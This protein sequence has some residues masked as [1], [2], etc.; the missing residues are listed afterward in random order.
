MPTEIDNL[1]QNVEQVSKELTEEKRG[2]QLEKII[3]MDSPR[4]K[5]ENDEFDSEKYA[6]EIEKR[7]RGNMYLDSVAELW[8]MRNEVDYNNSQRN[9]NNRTPKTASLFTPFTQPLRTNVAIHNYEPPGANNNRPQVRSS[10]W[11][12]D[13]FHQ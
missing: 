13:L 1:K 11:F 10:T 2:N 12:L 7:V 4:F 9:N 5:K 6:A 3:P 8:A